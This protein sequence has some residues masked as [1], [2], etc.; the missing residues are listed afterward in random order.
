[1]MRTEQRHS[2]KAGLPPGTIVFMG[3]QR[4]EHT[5]ITV[6]DYDE[7]GVRE[8]ELGTPE[9]ATSYLREDTVTWFNVTGLHDTGILQRLGE[10]FGLHPLIMED[11]ANTGQRPKIEDMGGY[12]FLAAKMLYRARDGGEHACAEHVSA[13]IGKNYVLSFQE[14]PGDVFDL[15]RERIRSGKGRIRRMGAD[16]LAYA[17]LDAIV[18]NYFVVLETVGDEIEELQDAALLDPDKAALQHIHRLKG[19]MLFLRKNLWPLREVV[20]GLDKSGSDLIQEATGPYLR[21]VYEHTVHVID[22]VE[23][24]RDMLSTALD[25]YM[26]MVSHRMNEVMKVL[27]IMAT[28]FIPLTFIAGIYGMNFEFM[29]ELKWRFGYGAVWL[30]MAAAAAGM[31]YYFRRRRWL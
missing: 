26:T 30:V 31:I 10:V 24:L 17:L 2:R 1:M 22:T 13:I 29:P 18:D 5:T 7:D 28:I 14:V 3:T 16:Y 8:R 19:E 15:I 25:M 20:A 12:L 4:V 23:N 6:I 9:E 21:D 11:V 27:T